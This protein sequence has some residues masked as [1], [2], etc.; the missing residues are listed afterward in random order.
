MTM[1][2]ATKK[3]LAE[4]L[5]KA[6]EKTR[7]KAI[8]KTKSGNSSANQSAEELKRRAEKMASEILEI[9]ARERADV[10][11]KFVVDYVEQRISELREE[12]RRT[13]ATPTPTISEV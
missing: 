11:Y 9:D 7:E 4:G 10:I 3:T 8:E 13:A 2:E 1:A 12:I 5:K 6:A